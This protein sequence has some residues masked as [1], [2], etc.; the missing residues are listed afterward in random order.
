MQVF[1]FIIGLLPLN[2]NWNRSGRAISPKIDL[3]QG[4]KYPPTFFVY[5]ID[6][7]NLNSEPFCTQI[8]ENKK[9][10]IYG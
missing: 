6:R 2:Q 4:Q 9:K 5:L 8:S 1:N 10:Y 3:A 7:K